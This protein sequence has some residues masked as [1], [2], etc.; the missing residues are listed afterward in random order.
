MSFGSRLKELRND[1]K[2]SQKQVASDIGI[3]ITTISQYE[4]NSRF[5]N[6][7]ILKKLCKY[8]HIS[9]DYLLGLTDE[10]HAPLSKKEAKSKMMMSEQM[11]VIFNLIDMIQPENKKGDN[12]E[13]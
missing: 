11:N 13:N 4:N 1:K 3:S 9:S 7:K 6:E 8:Y 12:N 10:K 5:P 2:A